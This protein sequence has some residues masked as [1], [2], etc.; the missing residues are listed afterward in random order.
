MISGAAAGHI[1]QRAAAVSV[2]SNTLLTVSKLIV[3]LLTLS[4][5]VLSE[6]LHSGLDLIAALM[7]FFAV[8]KSQ[9]PAD[10]DHMYGHGKFESISG[11]LEGMLILVA[12]AMIVYSAVSRILTGNVTMH[13]P[14]LGIIVMGVS[15]VVNIFVSR[16]L[17]RVAKQTDSVALEADAWHLRT[18]VWTSFGVLGGLTVILVAKQFGFNE[19]EHLDP[20]IAIG[21]AVVISRAAWGITRRSWDH[22]VDRALPPEEVEQIK[23]VLQKHQPQVIEFHR[24]RTRRSG[25]Q[26]EIDLHVRLPRGMSVEEAHAICDDLEN[27]LEELLPRSSVLIHVEPQEEVAHGRS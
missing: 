15:A 5:S 19:A 14:G 13:E 8:R 6:A 16:M 27:H 17:F 3:G 23:S 24:L 22:L 12:I 1:K 10:S 25:A 26:R 11:L 2:I 4:V 9:A 20:V 18:D 7:A 21:V